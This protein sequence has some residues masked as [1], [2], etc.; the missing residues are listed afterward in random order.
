MVEWVSYFEATEKNEDPDWL[1]ILVSFYASHL[2][3]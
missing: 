1:V 3:D 2:R